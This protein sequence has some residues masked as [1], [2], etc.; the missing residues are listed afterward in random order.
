MFDIILYVTC[1][2]GTNRSWFGLFF[3]FSP[4]I[5]LSRLP[6]IKT[7]MHANPEYLKDIVYCVYKINTETFLS[8]NLKI[9]WL[10]SSELKKEAI[11]LWT[12]SY[13]IPHVRNLVDWQMKPPIIGCFNLACVDIRI[14]TTQF[15]SVP[16]KLLTIG[17]G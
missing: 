5:K 1:I 2:T 14:I 16:A 6:R 8:I 17:N 13:Y 3:C 15:S 10:L 9:F 4:G 12:I 11:K 7:N